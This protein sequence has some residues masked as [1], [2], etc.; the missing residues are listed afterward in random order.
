MLWSAWIMFFLMFKPVCQQMTCVYECVCMYTCVWVYACVC[1]GH[2]TISTMAFL[3]HLLPY[4]LPGW[5]GHSLIQLHWL[6]WEP[7][8]ASC[9]CLP[10]SQ[11]HAADRGF[12][13]GTGDLNS[14]GP[15]ACM[16]STLPSGLSPQI[17]VK[18]LKLLHF[19]GDK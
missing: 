15:Q 17:P 1:R 9:F 7:Q 12:Q 18:N 6:A 16:A 2:R 4:S 10:P 11:V 5:G 14:E 8:G 19:N 3:E 13:M